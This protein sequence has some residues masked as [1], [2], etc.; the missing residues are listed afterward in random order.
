ME[1]ARALAQRLLEQLLLRPRERV[2]G[3]L[4]DAHRLGQ[5]AHGRPVEAL[6][7]EKA[8]G[9]ARELVAARGHI[10]DA[11]DR[12]VGRPVRGYTHAGVSRVRPVRR[13]G[14]DG[15]LDARRVPLAPRQVHRDARQLG[16]DGRPSRA[17]LDPPR[18]D[19]AAQARAH[20]EDPG[21]GRPRTADLP[22][23]RGP[24]EAAQRLPRRPRLG[25]GQVPQ[26]VPLPDQDVGR[27]RRDR[28]AR[29]CGGDRLAEGAA[30]VLVRAVRQDHEEDLLG[31]VVPHPP[32]P[33]RHP[34]HG[35]GDAGAVRA[36]AGGARPLVGAADALPRQPDPGR[37]GPDVRL[38]D[39]EP[40][41]R[42]RATAVPRRLRPADP[43]TRA[44]DPRPGAAQGRGDR[45][46][47]LHRA[48]LGQAA[49]RRD[50]PRACFAGTDRLP[51]AVAGARGVGLA[52]GAR[53][54]AARDLRSV[55]AGTQ[56]PAVPARGHGRR[57]RRPLCRDLRARAVRPAAGVGGA[58]ARP[59]PR[60]PRDP[61]VPGRV[62]PQVPPRRRLLDQGEAEGST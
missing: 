54:G 5:V 18:T 40:G 22:R 10:L 56:G 49:S 20:R 39:Q 6:L 21:R 37:R 14:R 61:R 48:R 26:R 8:R 7:G 42:G 19:A 24:R 41:E 45:P 29:R 52:S 16:A 4:L 43:R 51:A 38:A 44:G 12:S 58:L 60:R 53:G 59:A 28:L 47:G 57:T 23:R 13:A 27:R 34:R 36:R 3:A 1:R 11:N 15:R 9:R 50:R 25:Q 30:Q 46:V 31:G 62:R 33:R 17:R 2:E 35:D 55:Q 32:R